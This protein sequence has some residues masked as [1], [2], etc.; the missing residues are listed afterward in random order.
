MAKK[1]NDD[2]DRLVSNL[3]KIALFQKFDAAFFSLFAGKLEVA[4]YRAGEKII[5]EGDPGREVYFLLSGTVRVVKKTLSGDEYTTALLK[6]EYGVF[7]G[8]LGLLTED[9]RSASIISE[10]D[11]VLAKM[12]SVN[13]HSFVAENPGYG[14]QLTMGLATSIC[15]KLKK[16]NKDMVILYEALMGEIRSANLGTDL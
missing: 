10:T 9:T 5:N 14:A 11:S 15:H 2:G 3:R 4:G 13:F 7:F 6:D 12:S 16:A 8:E 1:T